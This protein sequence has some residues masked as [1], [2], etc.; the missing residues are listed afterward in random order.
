M[1]EQQ[2]MKMKVVKLIDVVKEI[3]KIPHHQKIIEGAGL[4]GKYIEFVR[5]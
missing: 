5:L 2:K 1:E 4:S 3:K